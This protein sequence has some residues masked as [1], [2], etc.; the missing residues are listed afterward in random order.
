MR[1]ISIFMFMTVFTRC[2]TILVLLFGVAILITQGH[3]CGDSSADLLIP[4]RGT[5][6]RNEVV[7]AR[8]VVS[9]SNTGPTGG[10]VMMGDD[11]EKCKRCGSL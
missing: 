11:V 8:T 4:F 3:F 1:S 9:P 10:K 5:S 2:L 7:R 6:G